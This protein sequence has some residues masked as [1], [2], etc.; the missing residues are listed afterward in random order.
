MKNVKLYEEFEEFEADLDNLDS[1]GF[2]KPMGYIMVSHDSPTSSNKLSDPRGNEAFRVFYHVVVARSL[3]E[4]MKIYVEYGDPG[5]SYNIWEDKKEEIKT[6]TDFVNKWVTKYSMGN[7]KKK[8][9]QPIDVQH[10]EGLKPKKM[11]SSYTK[12]DGEN[13]FLVVNYLKGLFTNVE[14]V[15]DET[16]SGDQIIK[17]VEVK[18]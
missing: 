4:A 15:F 17:Y 7:E 8:R 18:G 5:N 10:Y 12:I 6:F 16:L 2:G 14:E 1:L 9:T 11:V 13:P 3:D